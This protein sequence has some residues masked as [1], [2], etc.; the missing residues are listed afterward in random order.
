V[1]AVKKDP[2]P[3]RPTHTFAL[4]SNRL[5]SPSVVLGAPDST[6]GV[7]W[8][9]L[10]VGLGLV[11]LVVGETTFLGFAENRVAASKP[12]TRSRRREPEEPLPIHHVQLKR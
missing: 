5:A 9:L 2:P 1:A 7:S 11:L 12:P 8:L 4:G 10:A 6:A 3:A